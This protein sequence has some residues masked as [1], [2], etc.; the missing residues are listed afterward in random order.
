MTMKKRLLLIFLEVCLISLS[1]F[2]NP[3]NEKLS[4][5]EKNQLEAG[6]IV[7]KN[8]NFEKNICLNKNFSPVA[9]SL[10]SEIHKLNPKYLA[11]VIQYKRYKGNEDLPQ[12]LETLLNNVSDYAGIPYYSVRA[13]AWYN[14]YDSATITEKYTSDDKTVIKADMQMEPFGTVN[15]HIEMT[16]SEET[17]L[18]IAKNTNKLRYLDKFDCIWP[19]RMRICILLFR[20]GDNWVLYGIGGVNAPRIPFFTERIQTSFINRIR[21]FCTFIFKKF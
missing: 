13:Q 1:C 20:D 2:S 8:I 6:E 14:L 18:Y 21:T 11:E 7:I 12:R 19:E 15:E 16:K 10:L 5:D 9:D 3:F 17:I 4:E